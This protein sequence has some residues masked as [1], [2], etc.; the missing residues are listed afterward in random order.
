M[1]YD[2]VKKI[3]EESNQDDWIVDDETGSFS[4]KKDL[5]LRIERT[6]HKFNEFNEGWATNH[7]DERAYSVEY[8]VHYGSSFV[9]KSTLVSVDNCRATLPIPASATDLT[10]TAAD[11]NFAKIVA[12]GAR[13]RVDEYIHRSGLTVKQ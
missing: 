13:D 7:P 3:L 1:N 9:S 10:V 2:T 6:D 4:Y 12:T 5:N 11:V 8:T